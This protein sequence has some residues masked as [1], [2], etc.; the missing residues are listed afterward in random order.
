MSALTPHRREVLAAFL[1]GEPKGSRKFMEA[2]QE[3]DLRTL[4]LAI[5]ECILKPHGVAVNRQRVKF[6]IE[7]LIDRVT[8]LPPLELAAQQAQQAGKGGK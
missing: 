5:E 7:T 6:L 1:K 2:M 4:G 8:L 3:A